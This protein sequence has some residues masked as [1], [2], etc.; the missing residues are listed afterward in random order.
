MAEDTM[1]TQ[2]AV[3]TPPAPEKEYRG[4]GIRFVARL[5]DFI[6]FI[7]ITLIVN[8]IIGAALSAAYPDIRDQQ[9]LLADQA[10][11]SILNA[12][13]DDVFGSLFSEAERLVDCD[14]DSDELIEACQAVQQFDM[15]EGLITTLV[16]GLIYFAYYVVASATSLQGSLAKKMLGMKVVNDKGEKISF[17]QSATREVFIL[18][19]Y[20][21]AALGYVL[22]L[23]GFLAALFGLGFIVSSIVAAF[24]EKKQAL[25]DK[26]AKTYVVKAK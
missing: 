24:D 23:L 3:A 18:G 12:S 25:H 22:S 11:N 7:I 9:E 5:I 17:G 20:L 26:L 4:F 1:Q 10:A 2:A 21:F 16:A 6:I 13:E 19:Y 15:I 14:Y 8:A